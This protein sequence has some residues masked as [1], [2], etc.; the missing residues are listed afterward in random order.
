MRRNFVQGVQSALVEIRV[1]HSVRDLATQ[2]KIFDQV[3]NVR[4]F[5]W[6]FNF[7]RVV[8]LYYASA[9]DAKEIVCII[10]IRVQVGSQFRGLGHGEFLSFLFQYVAGGPQGDVDRIRASADSNHTV[11]GSPRSEIVGPECS[12]GAMFGLLHCKIS[13]YGRALGDKTLFRCSGNLNV[14]VIDFSQCPFHHSA[15]IIK[16]S[17]A[18]MYGLPGMELILKSDRPPAQYALPQYEVGVYGRV[19]LTQQFKGVGKAKVPVS[20]LVF[21]WS[22]PI[23]MAQK[24]QQ[25][26]AFNMLIYTGPGVKYQIGQPINFGRRRQSSPAYQI[27]LKLQARRNEVVGA[28]LVLYCPKQIQVREQIFDMVG[29]QRFFVG[30]QAK[31]QVHGNCAI[32]APGNHDVLDESTG[33]ILSKSSLRCIIHEQ[34]PIGWHEP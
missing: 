13:I 5:V 29:I 34:L 8:R 21:P 30:K 9:L 4:P 33:G 14:T 6:F 15:R 12:S 18:V 26:H 1:S 22:A 32:D 19:L 31:Y 3:G 7:L 20:I 16:D 27:S 24:P 23:D 2:I 25:E 10:D 11:G 17:Q 28:F